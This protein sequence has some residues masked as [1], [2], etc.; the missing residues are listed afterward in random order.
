MDPLSLDGLFTIDREGSQDPTV[1][2]SAD[3][4]EDASTGAST[5]K[6]PG[7]V[8]WAIGDAQEYFESL[9]GQWTAATTAGHNHAMKFYT[10]ALN[11]YLHKFGYTITPGSALQAE[12]SEEDFAE[13]PTMGSGISLEEATRLK[14]VA[15]DLHEVRTE[16]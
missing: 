7:R 4:D 3:G 14:K 15:S 10:R 11:G 9:R 5:R 12:L 8:S 1:E 6:K 13:P 16:P 2:R